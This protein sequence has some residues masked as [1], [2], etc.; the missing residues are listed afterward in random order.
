MYSQGTMLD[1]TLVA[2]PHGA[3]LGPHIG[4]DPVMT[5][6]IRLAI[7]SVGNRWDIQGGNMNHP[8]KAEDIPCHSGPTGN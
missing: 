7:E 3:V 2:I 6:E 8:L 5:V 1:E 4:V